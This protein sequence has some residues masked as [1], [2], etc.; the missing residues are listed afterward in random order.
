MVTFDRTPRWK[1]NI[2]RP[3]MHFSQVAKPQ[4]KAQ[5]PHF[6]TS[7]PIDSSPMDI[8]NLGSID[9]SPSPVSRLFHAGHTPYRQKESAYGC[10]G[11]GVADDNAIVLPPFPCPK[12]SFN[13]L[14]LSSSITD[15]KRIYS[16]GSMS[17]KSLLDIIKVLW[18]HFRR[19][20]CLARLF[21]AT[22]A[23]P[24]PGSYIVPLLYFASILGCGGT[25]S[26][27]SI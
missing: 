12:T 9:A 17:W 6:A 10:G 21:A 5:S 20:G 8:C 16:S 11:H 1:S 13:H 3:K 2:P 15:S 25:V 26:L 7:T 14:I 22:A 23:S 19:R 24:I 18:K 4:Q 27:L